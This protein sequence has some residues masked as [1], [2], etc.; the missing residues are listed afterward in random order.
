MDKYYH[1]ES[2][3]II[4]NILLDWWKENKRYFPWR[5]KK[6]PYSILIAEMLLRKTT[7]KQVENMYSSFLKKYPTP[8][9]LS[10][11]NEKELSKILTPLGIAHHRASLFIKFGRTIMDNYKGE[12]PITEKELLKL[13]GVGRYTANAVLSFSQNKNVPMVDT[14]FIRVIE[15]VFDF[16]S[17]KVRTRN[18]NRIWEFAGELIPNGKSREFNLAILDFASAVCKSRNPVCNACPIIRIC[19]FQKKLS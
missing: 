15:R 12:I 17:S 14:N 7:A 19:A 18:D 10:E 6:N 16:A 13:P 8:K 11:A 9:D 5:L 3:K 1:S 4:G 2:K